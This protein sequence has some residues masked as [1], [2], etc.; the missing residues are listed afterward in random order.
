LSDNNYRAALAPLVETFQALGIA[1]HIGGSVAGVSYGVSRT[2]ID[3]DLVVDLQAEQIHPLVLRLRSEYYIDEEMI[4]DALRDR[5]SFNLIHFATMFKVDIFI[6]KPTAY[7]Q[8]AFLRADLK[9]LD[10]EPNSPLFFVESVEDVILNKLRW[11]RLG[12][13]VSERQWSDLTSVMRVQ[14]GALD[15]VYLRQW[16]SELSVTDLLEQALNEAYH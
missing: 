13:G 7:D 11:Y 9:L 5:S 6:L 2:T 10:D 4:E 1:Y 8:Q 14:A 12:G 15:T 16:A 3:V